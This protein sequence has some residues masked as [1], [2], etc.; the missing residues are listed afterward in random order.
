MRDLEKTI[1]TSKKLDEEKGDEN[2]SRNQERNSE[3]GKKEEELKEKREKFKTIREK[4]LHSYGQ[5][6]LDDTNSPKK[7]AKNTLKY[8]KCIIQIATNIVTYHENSKHVGN[9][10]FNSRKYICN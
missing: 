6:A 1:E 4:I 7:I 2:D 5:H 9:K 8:K 3:L 10:S